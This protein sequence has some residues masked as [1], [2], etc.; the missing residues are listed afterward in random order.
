METAASAAETAGEAVDNAIDTASDAANS[1]LDSIDDALGS[2]VDAVDHNEE[3][4]IQEKG[5][6]KK[7]GLFSHVP[8]D[9]DKKD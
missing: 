2:A 9:F 3:P 8:E 1:A 6:E 5:P 7:G 4:F